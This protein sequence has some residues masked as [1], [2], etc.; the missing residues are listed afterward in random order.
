MWW[1]AVKC[2]RS[3]HDKVSDYSTERPSFDKAL[4][5]KAHERVF[6]NGMKETLTEVQARYWIVKG[7]S[8]IKKLLRKCLVCKRYEGK[9]Y[10]APIPPPP[11]PEFGVTMEPSFSSTGPLYIKDEIQLRAI[12]SGFSSTPTAL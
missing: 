7:R 10:T 5:L 9:P 3:V 8:L 1:E 6:H 11:L 4:V 2:R 12:R